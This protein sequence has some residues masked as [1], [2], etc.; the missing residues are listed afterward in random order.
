MRKFLSAIFIALITLTPQFL[1]AQTP[2]A[3]LLD[4]ED[5]TYPYEVSSETAAQIMSKTN[6]TVAVDVTMPASI[7]GRKVLVGAADPT[8]RASSTAIGTAASPYVGLGMNG[9][10]L[11][12]ITSSRGGDVYTS[13]NTSL[14]ASTNYKIVYVLDKSNTTF[15]SYINGTLESTNSLGSSFQDFAHLATNENAKVYV[16]AGV[17]NNT[18]GWDVFAGQIHSVQFFEGA[19]TDDEIAY[20]GWEYLFDIEEEEE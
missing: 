19:L 9:S 8:Q 5:A 15:K 6:L 14:S 17:V 7:S 2:F 4:V 11:A 13:R 10:N 3:K 16:G 1:Q 20:F 12:Y 18:T